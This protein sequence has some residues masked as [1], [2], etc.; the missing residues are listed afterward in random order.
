[1]PGRAADEGGCHALSYMFNTKLLNQALSS[2]DALDNRLQIARMGKLPLSLDF[3]LYTISS[4]ASLGTV[5]I[6]GEES[7]IGGAEQVLEA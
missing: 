6:L 4:L 5:H 1:M 3:T 7:T 2:H